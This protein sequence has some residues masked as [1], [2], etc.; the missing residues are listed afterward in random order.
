MPARALE[1]LLAA[2]P[3]TP[4][5]SRAATSRSR[6]STTTGT[7][8][9]LSA[10]AEPGLFRTA[11]WVPA[12]L[13][14]QASP[15]PAGDANLTPFQLLS[16]ALDGRVEVGALPIERRAGTERL[17]RSPV[18]G[19]ATLLIGGPLRAVDDRQAEQIGHR[20]VDMGRPEALIGLRFPPGSTRTGSTSMPT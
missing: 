18:H 17:T 2:W 14:R 11:F 5:T 10:R 13:Q 8:Y 3:I 16:T 20:L 1:Q 9:L 4:T 7:G 12:D 19:L 15:E 6:S